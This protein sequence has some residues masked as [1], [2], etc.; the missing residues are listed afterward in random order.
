MNKNTALITETAFKGNTKIFEITNRSAKIQKK[1]GNFATAH[2]NDQNLFHSFF[3]KN[4]HNLFNKNL[5]INSNATN[6]IIA[7]NILRKVFSNIAIF[8]KSYILPSI[9]ESPILLVNF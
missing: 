6:T 7:N 5:A 3:S 1:K 4:F 9:Q 2:K 8:Q